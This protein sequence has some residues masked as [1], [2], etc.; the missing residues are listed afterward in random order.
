MIEIRVLQ[1]HQGDCIFDV[2]IIPIDYEYQEL[3][4]YVFENNG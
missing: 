2:A 4:S 1:A 3:T